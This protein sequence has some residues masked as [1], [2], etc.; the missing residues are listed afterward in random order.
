MRE[1]KLPFGRAADNTI[2]SIQSVIRGLACECVCP[3]CNVPLVACKGETV[4]PYFRHYAEPETCSQARETALHLF[5]KQLIA[6]E[7][8]LALPRPGL[9]EI[10]TVQAEI[11]LAYG[12]RPDL[13]MSYQSGETLAVEIWVSHQSDRTKVELYAQHDQAAVE[14]DL[15]PYRFVDEADWPAIILEIADR[16]WLYP[17]LALRV[18]YERRRQEIIDRMREAREQAIREMEEAEAART[19]EEKKLAKIQEAEARRQQSLRVDDALALW[20]VKLA[21]AEHKQELVKAA[22]ERNKTAELRAA[23]RVQRER[24]RKPPNLHALIKAFGAY[25]LISPGAWV[26]YDEEMEFYRTR[27][28]SGEFYFQE[29]IGARIAS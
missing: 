8:R 11:T 22:E 26:R 28:R 10:K 21:Q 16:A 25:G 27:M 17:P 19:F 13:F 4:R 1:I 29:A 18:E 3:E 12:I 7:R 14:I 24:E 23:L 6:S 5:A 15:R 2:V 20:R 9:G